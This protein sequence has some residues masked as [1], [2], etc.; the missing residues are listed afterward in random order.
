MA[1]DVSTLANYTKE[2]EALLVTSSVFGAKT[3]QKI[4]AQGNVLTGVKSSE[5]INRI[6]TDAV[7]QSGAACGF[8]ASGTTAITQRAVVVGKIKVQEALC[9]KTL[10]S[11]YTQKAL[12]V[13]SKNES[14]PFEQDY[15]DKKSARIAAQN[16]VAIWQGDTASADGN[17]NKFDGLI[18]L[19]DAATNEILSNTAALTNG[20]PIAVATGVTQ[21]N[22]IDIVDGV[23]KALPVALLDK[24][25]TEIV[26]GWDLFRLYVL[27]LR[28]KNL[29]HYS[30]DNT[31]GELTIPGTNIKL[32]ALN[33]LNGTNRVFGF[34]WSNI[35]LGT[36]MLNEEE[37]FEIFFAKEAQEVRFDTQ[38]KLGVNVAFPDE[39]VSFKLV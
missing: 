22:I 36:D 28:E 5:Q 25:D 18:K 17:L 26:L 39:V 7:F 14:I 1:Y 27:A 4:S 31:D 12:Q 11:K 21:A 38:W 35:F 30:A 13:G 16:E 37:K 20:G 8:T 2:N 33:G 10:E 29:Y 23:F 24:P 32:V 3:Q 6:D 15:T 19:I 34:R 9:P